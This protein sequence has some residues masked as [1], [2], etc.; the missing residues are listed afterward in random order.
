MLD[1]DRANPVFKE[2]RS[3]VVTAR[4]RRKEHRTCYKTAA[5]D[6]RTAAM[7]A[8]ANTPGRSESHRHWL[9]D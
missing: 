6:H 1:E 2:T 5:D 4:D 8:L 3:F 9:Y 7:Y